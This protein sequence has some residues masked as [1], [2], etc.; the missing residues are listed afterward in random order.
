MF[1]NI[2]RLPTWGNLYYLADNGTVGDL[3]VEGDVFF[4]ASFW[5]VGLPY[6]F[7]KNSYLASTY[8]PNLRGGIGTERYNNPLFWYL[9]YQS[10]DNGLT[11][12]CTQGCVAYPDVCQVCAACS[13]SSPAGCPDSFDF[14]LVVFEEYEAIIKDISIPVTQNVVVL[15]QVSPVVSVQ[16]PVN[17]SV[18]LNT[19]FK[20]NGENSIV[21][22]DYDD[23][24]YLMCVQILAPS[25]GAVAITNPSVTAPLYELVSC[26]YTLQ[27]SGCQA[28]RFR[29]D[30]QNANAAL[31]NLSLTII[32]E[33]L[34][35]ESLYVML[36]KT[37]P[38]GCVSDKTFS[39]LPDVIVEIPIS[40]ST[41]GTA[42]GDPFWFEFVLGLV[43][44]FFFLC[45][46]IACVVFW[47]VLVL[48][49]Q[50]VQRILGEITKPVGNEEEDEDDDAIQRAKI[51]KY[52]A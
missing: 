12:E 27:S 19:A 9:T 6:Y 28:I 43:F 46:I 44:A 16:Y 49:I 4:N 32:T 13:P 41:A 7:T 30:V 34:A 10:P 18:V 37:T 1:T 48:D 5:Y 35:D 29:S 52:T 42:S 23:D 31:A 17:I 26:K 22:T 11:Y 8:S 51:L 14:Q 21:I 50:D 47:Y 39:L 40:A 25:G 36:W 33:V 38:V 45:S 20:F 2:T 24:V 15:S 3:I